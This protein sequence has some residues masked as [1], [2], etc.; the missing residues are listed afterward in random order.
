MSLGSL[1]R[2][3]GTFL[4]VEVPVRLIASLLVPVLHFLPVLY[5]GGSSCCLPCPRDSS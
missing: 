2:W 4:L 1:F 3:P 5:Y